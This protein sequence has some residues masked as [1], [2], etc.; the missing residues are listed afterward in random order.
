MKM[1]A[2]AVTKY[3]RVSP[4]KARLVAN[5]VR[6]KGV[7]DALALLKYTPTKG[8]GII[9]KTIHSAIANAEENV[10][11]YDTNRL[12]I[13][14]ITVD[15]GPPLKRY[16]PRAYGR[17]SAIHKPTAHVRVVLSDKSEVQ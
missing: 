2:K 12:Y 3:Q 1:V 5:A 8:A 6:G 9:L 15:A 14:E 16:M 7:E 10:K 4:R 17:A 11:F 13:S